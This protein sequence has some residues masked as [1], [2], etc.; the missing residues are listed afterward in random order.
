MEIPSYTLRYSKK[1]KY[2]QLR[3]TRGALELVIPEKR[4]FSSTI[5]DEFIENKRAWIIKNWNKLQKDY[6]D[7]SVLLPSHIHLKAINQV[8]EVKYVETIGKKLKLA[9]NLSRQIILMGNIN[10]ISSCSQLLKKWLKNIAQK[11]LAEELLKVSIETGLLFEDVSVRSNLTRWGSCSSRQNISLCCNLLFLPYSLMRHVL[12][13]ELCHT[14]VMNHGPKFW[15]LL[16]KF[17]P[18]AKDQAKRLRIAARE[19]PIWIK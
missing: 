16:E 8:W 13:H 10:D 7:T 15:Q 17:D 14:K 9:S 1:A 19:L 6:H 3:M 18:E 5:I 11:V 12:L 2:L 4:F